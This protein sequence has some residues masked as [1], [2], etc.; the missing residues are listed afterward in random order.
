MVSRHCLLDNSKN[1]EGKGIKNN[2]I[3]ILTKV[4]L[5][6]KFIIDFEIE[7]V[8]VKRYQ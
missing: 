6:K 2:P 3:S 5:I 7:I 4:K 1:F 8:H